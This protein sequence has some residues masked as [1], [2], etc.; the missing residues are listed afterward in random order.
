MGMVKVGSKTKYYNHRETGNFIC[1]ELGV[2][3]VDI[4]VAVGKYGLFTVAAAF[5]PGA[6]GLAYALG[7]IGY[8]MQD[9]ED[10]VDE[11]SLT[12]EAKKVFNIMADRVANGQHPGMMII[13]YNKM[14]YQ[15]PNGNNYSGYCYVPVDVDWAK[16]N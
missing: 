11:Y 5:M 16:D 2:D 8:G 15:S 12:K 6:V 1:D 9:I 14:Q 3:A 4:A 10:L 7:A 13:K